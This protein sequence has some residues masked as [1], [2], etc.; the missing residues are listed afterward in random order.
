MFFWISQK[1]TIR[2]RLTAWYIL[3]FGFTIVSFDIYLYI[4][5]RHSLLSQLDTTLQI[6]ASETF[7]EVLEVDGNHCNPALKI[8][9]QLEKNTH[10]LAE[11]GFVIQLVSPEGRIWDHI[12]KSSYLPRVIELHQG[13][14]NVTGHNKT[15]RVYTQSLGSSPTAGWLQVAQ[16]LKPISTASEK[17]L[18]LILFSFP[19]ILSF[20]AFG[21]LFL[22]ERALRTID[23]IT[24]TTQAISPDDFAQRINYQGSEDKVGRLALTIDRMLDRLQAAFENERR[25]IADAS[26]EL[27]TP[28]TVIKGQ[29]GVTLSRGRTV[30]E[31]ES[32]LQQLEREV[33]RLILI[34]NRLLFLTRL[35]Q[36]ESK[37]KYKLSLK[38]FNLSDLLK[39]IIEKI[40][41]LAEVKNINISASIEPSLHITGNS[42]HLISLFFNLLDNAIKYTPPEGNI[43]VKARLEK[44]QVKI[45]I[46]N[47][48][49]G[50]A[51]AD[52]PNLFKRFYR[53]ESDRSGNI[54]GSG[55]GLAIAYEI[56][57]LHGGTIHVT[58][59]L[60][61]ITTFTVELPS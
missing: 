51:A 34:A 24:R 39:V 60:N 45:T 12:G 44:G 25:F 11:A 30:E 3:I 8:T 58:S 19:L 46:M 50:I 21:S 14:T 29:I 48:G 37:Y 31:Y 55:L 2:I 13:Y 36:S 20:A 23:Q 32:T 5:I 57:R 49:K 47:T 26:H 22:A 40:E 59:Q 41:H 28:L 16:S 52:L 42:D 35:D 17:L 54:E 61:Q 9:S 56:A 53:A 10:R 18:A 27:R 4:Q 38:Y 6:A 7:V 43:R 15:W 33:D 1:S